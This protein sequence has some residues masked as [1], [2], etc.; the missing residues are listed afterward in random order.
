MSTFGDPVQAR[1]PLGFTGSGGRLFRLALRLNLLTVLTL[2][3]YRFW[4]RT[5][6]RRH[7]WNATRVDG[8]PLEYTGTGLEKL[9]GFLIAMVFLA[10]Y[11]TF[12]YVAL[13]YLGIALFG[14]TEIGS[15]LTTLPLVPLLFYAQYRARRYIL[16]RTRLRGIRFGQSPGAWRYVGLAILHGISVV[17]TLGLLYP[18]AHFHLERFRTDRSFYGDTSFAQGGRWTMLLGPWM[19]VMLPILMSLGL[20]GTAQTA[21]EP[22]YLL[23]FVLLM[24]LILIA[25]VH[26]QVASF[27]RLASRKT[28]GG[29]TFESHART[30]TVIGIYILGWLLVALI[31]SVFFAI[32]G[33]VAGLVLSG[34][35]VLTDLDPSLLSATGP[36]LGLVAG[37]VGF[38]VF[39]TALSEVFITQPLLRH[40]VTTLSLRAPEALNAIRQRERDEMIEAEGF[41]DALDV[42]GAF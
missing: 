33:I 42:G 29:V 4:L 7:Y 22:L 11:L 10:V 14:S 41:A 26:Y 36:L 35:G 32:L 38:I 27:R 16:A 40:Y 6:L 1:L 34:T 5:K 39:T 19:L 17:L 20:L 13:T 8:S 21:G 28:L 23:G 37:Y 18:R 24:P 31:G 9:L 15:A 30:G 12:A 3:I 2:G 25:W